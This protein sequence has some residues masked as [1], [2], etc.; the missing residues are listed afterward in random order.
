MNQHQSILVG[1][2]FSECCAAALRQAL[3]ISKWNQSAV[4]TMHVVELPIVP[5]MPPAW[6]SLEAEVATSL[7]D[8]ARRRWHD[9]AGKIENAER[10]PFEVEINSPVA[11]LCRRA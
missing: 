4:R 9:F 10:L 7:K 6:E 3:R 11:A 8:D 1:V 2:D 5:D